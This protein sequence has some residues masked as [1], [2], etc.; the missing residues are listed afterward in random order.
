MNFMMKRKR[1]NKLKSQYG[2][3]EG[4]NYRHFV[5]WL[6]SPFRTFARRKHIGSVNSGHKGSLK[7]D[8]SDMGGIG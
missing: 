7:S 1:P 3:V 6:I 4:I 5:V 2:K 8:I